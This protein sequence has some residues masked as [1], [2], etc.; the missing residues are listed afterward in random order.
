M[1]KQQYK[2]NRRTK[3]WRNANRRLSES[4]SAFIQALHGHFDG[5]E[6]SFAVDYLGSEFLSKLND[7]NTVPAA[8]RKMAAIQ[9]WKT[10]EKRNALTNARLRGMDRGYNILPRVTFYTFLGFAQRLISDILGPLDDQIVLGSM[11]GGASTSRR[12]TESHPAQKYVG[13]A[14][15]T[16]DANPYV[17]LIHRMSGLY[18]QYGSFYN[19]REVEGAVLFTVPKKSD[20]DRCA[21]KEPDINMYLQKGVGSHIRSRLRRFGVN[22][23]D[24]S[25]N[26]RLARIG[27]I[28]GSLAT[29][30]LSSASDT[31]TIS[32]VEALLPRDWF[33]YLNDIRSHHVVVEDTIVTTEMFSSMGNGFTFELQSLLFYVLMRTTSYFEGISGV[34]SVY[35]DDLIIPTGMYDSATWVLREFGFLINPDKSFASGPFRESCGGHYLNGDDVTPFYLKRPATRLTDVIRVANQL[36]RWAM[37]DPSRRYT[38]PST[39][40]LWNQLAAMI[41]KSLW[42]GRDYAVDT[43]LVSP[44]ASRSRLARVTE[45]KEIDELGKYVYWHDRNRNRCSD[46]EDLGFEPVKTETLCRIRKATPGAPLLEDLFYQELASGPVRG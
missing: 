28:D 42:G 15:V 9:K 24:Q 21:C 12:R 26:R 27:S 7:E 14:D 32:C 33:L 46:P 19:L 38:L 3:S 25:V 40:N 13:Q 8:A 44:H 30:D 23:N 45:D 18:R 10:T 37:A 20:I 35:G 6:G 36:R 29:L 34:I 16:R 1:H 39:Y 22:L 4:E 5:Q 17:D 43:Q 11:S 2:H 41:P 31:I